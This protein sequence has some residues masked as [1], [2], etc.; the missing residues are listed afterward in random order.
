MRAAW[1]AGV[2]LA[3]AAC[4]SQETGGQG[5]AVPEPGSLRCER[6]LP[7]EVREPLL[8]GFTL[9]SQERPCPSCGPLCSFRSAREPD[10]LVSV[11][12]DC[13]ARY[14][15]EDVGVLL[16]PTLA[17]GGEEVPA[18]GRAAARSSP[19]PGLL[20]VLAW[21]E[22]TPCLVIV[23]W[24]GP[25]SERA[26]ALAERVLRST[27]PERLRPPPPQEPPGSPLLR[28]SEPLLRPPQPPRPPAD[29]GASVGP[30][31]P[32]TTG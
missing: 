32:G 25:H 7:A 12:F 11:A 5:E 14:A 3:L 27:T 23:T 13:R 19:A 2:A 26:T 21:D 20:Q 29:A 28:P 15:R 8:S 10:T 22:D 9:H 1:A 6:L 16:A 4:R 31:A 24:L 17:A 30:G 18:L